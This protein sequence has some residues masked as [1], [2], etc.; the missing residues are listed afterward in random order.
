MKTNRGIFFKTI[1]GIN[2]QIQILQEKIIVFSKKE[3]FVEGDI[4]NYACCKFNIISKK[5]DNF[6][7]NVK[8]LVEI[9]NEKDCCNEITFEDNY[10]NEKFSL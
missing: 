7:G 10:Y 9:V 5:Y 6:N 4:T 3:E 2:K 8:I 1:D